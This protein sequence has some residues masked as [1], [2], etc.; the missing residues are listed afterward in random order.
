ME[1]PFYIGL[2]ENA[3]ILILVAV[4]YDFIW[5]KN[6]KSRRLPLQTLLGLLVGSIGIILMKS[7]WV[8]VEGI[9]FD[10]RSVLL[11]ITGLFLGGITTVIAMLIMILYRLNIGGAGVYMGIVVIITS[12]L[13]GLLWRKL[14]PAIIRD[15]KITEIF[16]V[17]FIV[18]LV[19][20]ACTI[21]LPKENRT[22]TLKV[23][24]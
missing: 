9:V 1:N 11:T 13:I 14:R 15:K 18:H 5:L 8:L 12:A 2:I 23:I 10:T 20:L 4:L 22:V 7:P 3:A 17:S 6:D 16:V 24:W 21:L 19:M